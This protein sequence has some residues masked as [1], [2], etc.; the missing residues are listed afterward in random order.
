MPRSADETRRRI[1]DAAAG[2][3]AKLRGR[4]NEKDRKILDELSDA[5]AQLA[6]LVLA[7]PKATGEAAYAKELARLETLV[8]DLERKLRSRSAAFR[9]KQ[10]TIELSRVQAAIPAGAA[11]I[12]IIAYR[13][14]DP[15]AMT[16]SGSL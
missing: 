9:A 3:V 8:R 15:D 5:R 11:L 2:T 16:P 4:M 7:G 14:Y 10:P 1:L 13:R 12:E 6:K